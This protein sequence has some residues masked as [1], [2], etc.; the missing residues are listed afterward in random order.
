VLAKKSEKQQNNKN[1]QNEEEGENDD[2]LDE[3]L[4]NYTKSRSK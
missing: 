1:K 2:F 4:E 3:E